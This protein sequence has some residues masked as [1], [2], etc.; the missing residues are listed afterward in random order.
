MRPFHPQ[1]G[2]G[3]I[4]ELRLYQNWRFGNKLAG[5]D[6]VREGSTFC[7]EISKFL[8]AACTVVGQWVGPRLLRLTRRYGGDRVGVLADADLGCGLIR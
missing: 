6:R 5:V 8:R 4:C 1:V 3:E 2:Y 7:K